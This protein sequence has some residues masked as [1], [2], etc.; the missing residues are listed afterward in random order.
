[1]DRRSFLRTVAGYGVASLSD[2]AVTLFSA[3]GAVPDYFGLHPFIDAHPEAVFIRKTKVM[4]KTDSDGKKRESLAL[5][6]QIF[7]SR[8]AP[9]IPLTNKFAIKPNLT[10]SRASGLTYA[11]ITDPF[12]IE[13]L[14]GGL[15][16]AGVASE[17]IYVR[18]GLALDQKGSGY[19]EMTG[20]CGAHYADSECRTPMGKECPDGVVFRRTKYLGPFNYPDSYLIN[21]AKFKAHSMGLTLCV[22]NLQGT[23]IQPYIRFCYPPVSDILKD[24]QSDASTH[25]EALYARHERDGMPRWNTGKGLYMERWVQRTL[26]NY[27]LIRPTIGLNIIEGVYAQNGDGFSGGPGAAGGPD[28]FQTNLLIFGKD[29]F[30]VD[31]IGH[32]LGGHEPGNFGL[33]H[34]AKERGLSTALNPRNI[35]VYL[36]EDGGPT[37]T[38]L[39]KLPR[40]PLTTLYL[41]KPDEPQYH[42]CDEPFPYPA[43]PPA[44]SIAG[45]VAPE[46]RVLGQR[47]SGNS[48]RALVVEYSLPSEDY[49]LLEL[50]D[51]WGLRVGVLAEGRIGRGVHFAEWNMGRTGPGSYYCRFRTGGIDQA[52]AVILAG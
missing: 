21:V 24:I 23:N 38:P 47:K 51:S 8:N 18:E 48:C 25:V 36:W 13:G 32:W 49:A 40:T 33:F 41:Q 1:M 45:R 29:A 2:S 44:V 52:K 17:K 22:K 43:E 3:P 9:G 16:R 14:I 5:A 42:L 31:I 15:N 11:I 4:S 39:D 6:E 50:Y 35:P 30:R 19:I 28:I 26:D 12:V 7:T 37:L 34:I 20:R 10:G 27:S 46:F